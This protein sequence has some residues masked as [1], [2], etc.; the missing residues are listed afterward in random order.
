MNDVWKRS[1]NQELG[2][3]FMNVTIVSVVIKAQRGGI[4]DRN[5]KAGNIHEIINRVFGNAERISNAL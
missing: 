2:A 3:L 4:R 5:Y 1:L